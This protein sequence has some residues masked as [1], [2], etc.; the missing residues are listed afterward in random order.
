MI[1]SRATRHA[2]AVVRVGQ[3]CP[4]GQRMKST[5]EFWIDCELTV[6]AAS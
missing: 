3:A 5:S 2:P 4:V 1:G 6:S